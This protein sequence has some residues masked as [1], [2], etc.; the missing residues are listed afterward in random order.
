M[1]GRVNI[2]AV[3]VQQALCIG[4]AEQSARTWDFLAEGARYKIVP[5]EETLTDINLIELK[6]KLPT[7]IYTEKFSRYREGRETA[8]DWEWWV[9]DRDNWLGLRLQAKRLDPYTQRYELF[10]ANRKKALEQGEALTEAAVS[11]AERLYPVYCFY[12]TNCAAPTTAPCDPGQKDA[13]AYGC[14]VAP[15]PV[16]NQLVAR[17]CSHFSEFEPYSI[18][19][20]CLFCEEPPNGGEGLT[21]RAQRTLD[22]LLFADHPEQRGEIEPEIPERVE[23]VWRT[24]QPLLQPDE[25]D[26]LEIPDLSHIMLATN[27]SPRPA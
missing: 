1:G 24:E 14:T 25:I 19:W 8:A 18:P 22:E 2:R 13:T 7:L 5:G 23:L 21:V 15:A 10:A 3:R 16:V 20:S 11:G 4:F 12:N 9:G 17:G 6:R 26:P 27:L